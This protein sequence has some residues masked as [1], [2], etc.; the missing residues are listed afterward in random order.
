MYAASLL[1]LEASSYVCPTGFQYCVALTLGNLWLRV[2]DDCE[3]QSCLP[4]LLSWL[5]AVVVKD[6]L[7]TSDMQLYFELQA[8]RL[9]QDNAS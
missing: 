7:L 5:A 9:K 3:R 2:L 8:A 1:N 6:R 4:R